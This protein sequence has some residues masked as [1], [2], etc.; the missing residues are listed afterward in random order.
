VGLSLLILKNYYISVK[1]A[2]IVQILTLLFFEEL[3]VIKEW[4]LIHSNWHSL[5][6]LLLRVLSGTIVLPSSSRGE[7]ILDI[8]WLELLLLCTTIHHLLML[9]LL[10]S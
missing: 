1:T 7:N 10:L 9:H 2:D 6:L 4:A 3:L 8:H 5:I